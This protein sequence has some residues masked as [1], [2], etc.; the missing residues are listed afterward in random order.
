MF[1]SMSSSCVDQVH[2]HNHLMESID[3]CRKATVQQQ[4]AKR[5]LLTRRDAFCKEGER[6]DGDNKVVYVPL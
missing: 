1:E 2:G 5:Q 6:Y 3:I 4:P